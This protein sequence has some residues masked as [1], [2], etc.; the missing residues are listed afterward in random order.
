MVRR[1]IGLEVVLVL[2]AAIS[3]AAQSSGVYHSKLTGIEFSVPAGWSIVSEGPAA[4]GA[5]TVLLKDSVTNLSALVWLKPQHID[6]ADIATVLD[7]RLEAKLQQRANWEGYRYRQE[8]VR[9]TTIGGHEALS[10][11]AEYTIAGQRKVEYLTWVDSPNSRV[12]FDAR[13]PEADLA[14]FESRFDQIIQSVVF[15]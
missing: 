3:A 9:R 8:T 6:P 7:R 14:V 12:I 10:V 13:L 5:Y 4:G 1:R 15:P 2:A 11:V